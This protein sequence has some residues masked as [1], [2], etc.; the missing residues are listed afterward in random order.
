MGRYLGSLFTA[1]LAAI[2]VAGCGGDGGGQAGGDAAG[3]NGGMTVTLREE[4]GSGQTGEAT[5]TRDEAIV[6]VTPPKKFKGA[7]QHADIIK[8]TCAEYNP[9]TPRVAESLADISGGKS[10]TPLFND[11]REAPGTFSVVVR[12][13]DPPYQVVACG[14]FKKG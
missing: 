10:Q 13:Q 3:Q 12:A 11:Y 6:T 8:G 5:I 9:E 1:G 14:E 2:A 4:N 7:M